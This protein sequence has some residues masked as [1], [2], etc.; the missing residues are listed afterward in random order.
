[1]GQQDGID[2][3]TLPFFVLENTQSAVKNFI[4][5]F[6]F[7]RSNHQSFSIQPVRE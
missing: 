6:L 4:K 3:K 5:G 1:M 7:H 2:G